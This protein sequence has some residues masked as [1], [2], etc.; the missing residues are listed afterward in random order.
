VFRPRRLPLA[1]AGVMVALAIATSAAAQGKSGSAPGKNKGKPSTPPSSSSLPGPTTTTTSA[2]PLAT[3]TGASPLSW[4]D[5]ASLLPAGSVMLTVSAMRWSGSGVSEIDVP[6]VDATFGLTNRFQLSAS[7]PR[8]VGDPEGSGA[9]GGLGTSYFSGKIAILDDPSFKL[10]VSPLLEVL[11]TG[12]VRSL[13]DDESRYQVGVPVSLEVTAGS[14]RVFG[15]TG[16]FSRGAWFAGAGTGVELTP[17]MG[18]SVSFTRSWATSDLAG[19][20]RNR[21]EVSGG[22]SYFVRPQVAVYGALGRTIATSAENGAG[23]SVGGGVAFLFLS[24][25]AK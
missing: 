22:V 14:V 4:M 21:S 20:Q 10:A 23:T 11:G 5:D 18:A 13:P 25:A 15:V 17:R 2:S 12:A 8:V 7:V 24:S 6:I 19:I 9:V 1:M 16:F 3:A